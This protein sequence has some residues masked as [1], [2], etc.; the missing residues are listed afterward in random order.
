MTND[1]LRAELATFCHRG[2]MAAR[3][4]QFIARAESMIANRVRALENINTAGQ[5]VEANRVA[6]GVYNL[7][8]DFLGFPK[9]GG[10]KPSSTGAPAELIA[11]GE[12]RTYATQAPVA[13]ASVFGRRLEL[14]GTPSTGETIDLIYFFRLPALAPAGGSDT[15]ALLTATPELYIHGALHWLHLDAQDID[16]SGT[17]KELFEAEVERVNLVAQKAMR[18]GAIALN[19]AAGT[20]SSM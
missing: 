18:S 14:R 3:I 4:P 19:T 1:E 6:G 11:L 16:M 2:D 5:L 13:F 8:A 17:H 10:I 9:R 15:N 7:P 12:L 20:R